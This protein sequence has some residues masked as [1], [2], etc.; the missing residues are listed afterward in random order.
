MWVMP[1][2]LLVP[3]MYTL[4]E[5]TA[6]GINYAR[7]PRWHLLIAVA[8]ALANL[9]LNLLLVPQ[10]G[11]RGAALSTGI[12][13][14]LFFTARTMA[15]QR[16][17]PLH[18]RLDRLYLSIT[19]FALACGACSFASSVWPGYAAAAIALVGTMLLYRDEYAAL[20]AKARSHRAASA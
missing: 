11:A 3:L 2:L 19:L 7:R 10:L 18:L 4:S 17:L 20:L 12:A 13:Y 5:V 1:F 9:G 16:L 6:G 14:V 15:A 8:C